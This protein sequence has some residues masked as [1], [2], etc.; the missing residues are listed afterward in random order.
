MKQTK[1]K[2]PLSVGY[3]VPAD[4]QIP[5]VDLVSRYRDAIG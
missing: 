3:T 1:A 5:F 4:G 2:T